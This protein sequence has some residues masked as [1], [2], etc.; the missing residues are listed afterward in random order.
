MDSA[1]AAAG[2]AFADIEVLAVGVG[3][4]SFTGV[5]V[6]VT[7]F[8]TLAQASGKRLVGV[9]TLA[10]IA[11]P[12]AIGLSDS[13]AVVA[14]LPSRRGEV[15]AAA[16]QGD[17]VL[18][19]PFA[20]THTEL[21]AVIDELSDE[22]LVVTTG[23]GG[24]FPGQ[25]LHAPHIVAPHPVP[26]ALAQLAANEAATGRWAD[27]LGLNPKYVVAPAINQHKDPRT[28]ERLAFLNPAR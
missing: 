8:R 10:A 23:P 5:R 6:A 20:A 7:T 13:A 17:A 19:E 27:P 24:L 4:G 3:P 9:D 2:A 12:L 15:Y 26:S 28:A 18:R 16:Y 14:L 21:V 11:H 25:P 1:L 22:T